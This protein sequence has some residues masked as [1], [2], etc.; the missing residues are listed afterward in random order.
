MFSRFNN[1]GQYD[2]LI[3]EAEGKFL[4]NSS[5]MSAGLAAKMISECCES[6][7]DPEVVEVC[8]KVIGHNISKMYL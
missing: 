3:D 6:I 5:E 8:E 7:R 1:N 2:Q 4:R